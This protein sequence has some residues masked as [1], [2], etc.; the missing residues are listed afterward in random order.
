ME[1]AH[2]DTEREE[3][4]SVLSCLKWVR[5]AKDIGSLLQTKQYMIDI[6]LVTRTLKTDL[7]SIPARQSHETVPM[8][9]PKA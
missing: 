9:L 7:T 6:A 2:E 4:F 3:P 5:Q 8:V 1:Q